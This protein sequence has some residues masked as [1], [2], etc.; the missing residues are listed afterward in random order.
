MWHNIFGLIGDMVVLVWPAAHH[1][2]RPLTT[3][4]ISNATLAVIAIVASLSYGFAIN[5]F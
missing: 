3:D 1:V 2:F 4:I 5:G